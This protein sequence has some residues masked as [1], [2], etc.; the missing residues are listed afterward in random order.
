[1]IEHVGVVGIETMFLD[2]DLSIFQILLCPSHFIL[3]LDMKDMLHAKP[4]LGCRP[5]QTS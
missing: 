3:L 4:T 1:M 5:H 2:L